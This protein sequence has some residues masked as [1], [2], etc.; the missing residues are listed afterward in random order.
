[1]LK[2]DI[3]NVDLIEKKKEVVELADEEFEFLH[4]Y[5]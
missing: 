4:D 1:M 5:K 3:I 2:G